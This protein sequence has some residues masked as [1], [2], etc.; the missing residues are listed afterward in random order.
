MNGQEDA[1]HQREVMGHVRLITI[2][3]IGT[4]V[5]WPEVRLRQHHPVLV[6]A[7]DVAADRFDDVM[8]FGEVL[9]GGA[10]ALHQIRDGVQTQSVNAHL[11][12]EI[13]HL[14]HLSQ[15]RRVVVV[16]IGLVMAEPV[17]EVCIGLGVPRPVPVL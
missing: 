7:V 5:R 9:A 2:A 6:V 11:E 3:E 10:L 13:H 4:N 15:H 8:G 14:E 17:P 16:E 12:P 1:R